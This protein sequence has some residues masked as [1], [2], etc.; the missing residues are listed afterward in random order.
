MLNEYK[1]ID[2][3]MYQQMKKNIS[4]LSHAY[5][6]NLNGNIY[7]KDMIMAFVKTIICGE[8]NTIEEYKNCDLCKR[9]DDGNYL[10]L[11]QIEKDGMWIKKEQL[12]ELQDS[13]SKKAIESNKRI[14][15]IHE[16]EKLNK[17]AANSLLKFLEEPQEGI[18][19]ILLTNNINQVFETIVSRCQKLTFK[20]NNIEEFIKYNKIDKKITLNKLLFSVWKLHSI[21]DTVETDIYEEFINNV[22]KYI[23]KYE[24]NGY[25]MIIYEKECFLDCFKEKDDINKFF[26]CLILFYRDVLKYKIDGQVMYYDDYIDNIKNI[27]DKNTE[28]QLI[29]KI[30]VAIE[31]E[32]LIK[33]NINTNLL[34][35]SLIIDMERGM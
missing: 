8:H 21:S 14:Y 5:L 11:K 6:F 26:E 3:I 22:L 15:I 34:I 24:T 4:N 32:K 1:D 35:D 27:S 18:I 20:K 28:L 31:K 29:T 9:I 19:A 16:S 23:K 7:A 33:N 17:S 30:N 10:E 2:E 25:K 13:F 12:D